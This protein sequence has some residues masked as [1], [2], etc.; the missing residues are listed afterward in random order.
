M[1]QRPIIHVIGSYAVGMTMMTE[2]FPNVGETVSGYGF[3][4]LH[5]GKG[6]N[7]AVGAARLGA[8]VYFTSC[9]GKDSMGEEAIAMLKN[10]GIHTETVFQT[11]RAATGVGFVMVGTMGENEILIDLGANELLEKEQIDKA[12]KKIEAPDI[13]LVQF[14]ANLNAVT[15]AVTKAKERGIPVVV[16][17]APYRAHPEEI[18]SLADYITPNQTEAESLLDEKVELEGLIQKLSSR[19]KNNVILTAGEN[20]AYLFE[21]N[22]IKNIPVPRVEAKD[23]TG[24]GDC[25]NA[26]FAVAIAEGENMYDAVVF[27]NT[28]A[29]LSVQVNGVVESLPRR[30]D[31]DMVLSKSDG[32]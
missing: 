22:Q 18:I 29:S 13:L 9:V 21:G 17:P 24:A 12:F 31:V 11:D 16:N 3:S 23:T 7:Q 8:E 30:E 25:F 32:R 20:G 6:S 15:Y 26:A 19:Y 14:E 10:E 28:A 1:G 5:G 27:A 2:R 4:M